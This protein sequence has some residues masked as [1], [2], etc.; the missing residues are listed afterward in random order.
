MPNDGD[1]FETL[2]QELRRGSLIL[3]VLGQLKDEHYG[4]TLRKAL[5]E[6][7]VEIEEGALYPMLRR[8]ESQGLLA[9]EWR[10]E[11]RRNKRFYRLSDEGGQIL[12]RLTAEW[13]GLNASLSGI[14][15]GE[16]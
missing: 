9:S 1:I 7:G 10:E 2:R 11:D 4:Y 12:E 16:P 8:L 13:R 5:A 15:K 6:A 14:L 3:A